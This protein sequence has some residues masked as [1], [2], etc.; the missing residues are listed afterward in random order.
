MIRISAV[1][2]SMVLG[3]MLLSLGA[4]TARA[5]LTECGGIY[6]S[7]D[8]KCEYRKQQECTTTC[9]PETVQTSCV[10][11]V[12]KGCET[13][14]NV[15]SSSTCTSGCSA[16]CTTDCQTQAA[17]PTP[18]DCMGLC[19]SGCQDDC[20]QGGEHGACCSHNCSERC[21]H[22]CKG[23]PAPVAQPAQ[24]GTT[25]TN[26]CAGSCTAQANTDCQIACQDQMYTECQ[27]EEI[28]VCQTT[29]MDGDGAIFCDGQYV[30]A[31]D[32]TSC[33][34]QL[35]SDLKIDVAVSAITDAAGTVAEGTKDAASSTKKKAKGMCSV[36][37]FGGGN[38]LS[39]LGLLGGVAGALAFGRYRKRRLDT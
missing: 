30:D 24:C 23:M 14:C 27:T 6:L 37:L 3:S 35:K 12:Y 34:K 21:E 11:K 8:S 31:D 2:G 20:K 38:E 18:K 10:A 16:S 29:C 17:T 22:E 36:G 25:C 9:M 33:A 4:A 19:V 1:R 32:R 15:S 5:E 28:Q 39:G 26:A 7:S 13:S